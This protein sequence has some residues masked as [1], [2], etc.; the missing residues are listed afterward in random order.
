MRLSQEWGDTQYFFF[1]GATGTLVLRPQTVR[2][3]EVPR[4]TQAELGRIRK[5]KYL[6]HFSTLS[7]AEQKGI[8]KNVQAGKP[9]TIG[10]E[11][12]PTTIIVAG[13]EEIRIVQYLSEIMGQV[14]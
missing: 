4:A 14:L 5:E 8:L 9:I 13:P 3:A 11:N 6:A 1:M 10:P 7:K 2:K 12:Q